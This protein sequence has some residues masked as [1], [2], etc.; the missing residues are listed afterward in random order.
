MGTN[1]ERDGIGSCLVFWGLRSFSTMGG[2]SVVRIISGSWCSSGGLLSLNDKQ[3]L[4]QKRK[5]IK[6]LHAVHLLAPSLRQLPLQLANVCIRY[7]CHVDS[8]SMKFFPSPWLSFSS[9][10]LYLFSPSFYHFSL[11]LRKIPVCFFPTFSQSIQCYLFPM[12]I[13]EDSSLF[14]T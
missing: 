11:H 1:E 14:F 4:N 8:C 6:A 7:S 5:A 12:D 2:A 9:I 3:S 13:K 10:H